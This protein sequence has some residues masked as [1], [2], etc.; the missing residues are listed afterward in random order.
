MIPKSGN[1]FSDRDHAPI[2]FVFSYS[3]ACRS[4]SAGVAS[5]GRATAGRA[6][7]VFRLRWLADRRRPRPIDAVRPD[8]IDRKS[9]AG[10]PQADRSLFLQA[11]LA[12]HQR[13]AVRRSLS[14]RD[15]DRRARAIIAQRLRP[16]RQR[17]KPAI[18]Q[19]RHAAR[20]VA[21][22]AI[23]K[24]SIARQPRVGIGR[25]PFLDEER[26]LGGPHQ[27]QPPVPAAHADA[28]AVGG[29]QDVRLRRRQRP[30]HRERDRARAAPA[31]RRPQQ[32]R[33]G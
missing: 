4:A 9:A 26:I 18:R 11:L 14:R 5:T 8:R 31:Q 2:K 29:D 23:G 17:D 6:I 19:L 10:S 3:S 20:L 21:G 12:D 16:Q 13:S 33:A 30:N 28:V 25:E 24:R 22:D 32:S 1:R 7:A 27:M 15:D